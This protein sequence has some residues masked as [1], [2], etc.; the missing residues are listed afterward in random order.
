MRIRMKNEQLKDLIT[1]LPVKSYKSNTTTR[2]VTL[3]GEIAAVL[4]YRQR[5]LIRVLQTAVDTIAN[6]LFIEKISAGDTTTDTYIDNLLKTNRFDNLQRDIFKAV[7]R[8]GE[9]Y[10]LVRYKNDRPSFSLIDAYDG[11]TGA[12]YVYSIEDSEE[13]EY[14]INVWFSNGQRRVDI[15]FSDKVEHYKQDR[16]GDWDLFKTTDW[17]DNDNQ[18]LGIALIKFDINS[19]DIADAIQIQRDINEAIIDNIAISRSMGF[20]YRYTSGKV[21]P[22]LIQNLYGSPVLDPTGT[23]IRRR[24]N[25]SPGAIAHYNE[26]TEVQQLDSAEPN[27]TLIDKLLHLLSLVT[28]VPIHVFQGGD[29]PSGI[30]LIQSETRI[31]A[32]VE[33]HIGLLTPSFEALTV[34]AMR[35]SNTFGNTRFS[36]DVEVTVEWASPEVYTMDMQLE[37]RKSEI[38]NVV[39]LRNAGLISIE[40][41]VRMIHKDWDDTQ[42]A[43]EVARIQGEDTLI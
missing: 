2:D 25:V 31:N 10:V 4:G 33:S 32:K 6:K 20:P 13:V 18:P 23:P 43:N 34:A 14:A 17:T 19:S 16:D 41:A 35:L 12:A 27:T 11:S 22:T 36:L 42:I 24:E 7:V 29:F 30:A 39:A 8:D 9:T 37:M 21:D 1:N 38:A 26:G 28:T 40:E 5:R 15:Y 3:V